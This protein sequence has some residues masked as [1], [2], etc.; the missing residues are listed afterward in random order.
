MGG[1]G[2]RFEARTNVKPGKPIVVRTEATITEIDV[3]TPRGERSTITRGSLGH[4]TFADTDQ[5]GVYTIHEQVPQSVTRRFTVNL[6]NRE[7]SDIWPQ[8]KLEI[9][10]E[11]VAGQLTWEPMR[12]E[13]WKYVLIVAL[14]V[15]LLEWYIF[16][17]RVYL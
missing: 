3:E 17:R 7:E 10:H 13:A 5:I 15:L 16:N 11:T 8:P 12:R 4:F 14:A 1:R 2:G 9:G 6:F